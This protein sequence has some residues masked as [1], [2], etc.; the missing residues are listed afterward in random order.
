MGTCARVYRGAIYRPRATSCARAANS[1]DTA[2]FSIIYPYRVNLYRY[3]PNHIETGH[4][5]GARWKGDGLNR[6]ELAHGPAAF[7]DA[8]T[9]CYRC[10]NDA[11]PAADPLRRV[12]RGFEEAEGSTPAAV[13]RA[14]LARRRPVK[15]E[16]R[17][18][19]GVAAFPIESMFVWKGPSFGDSLVS[20]APVIPG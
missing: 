6:L 18:L 16:G 13:R 4:P 1:V 8:C 15:V 11:R 14:A 17:N 3:A 10:K 5:G 19:F 20:W 9:C 7:R 12:N 2:G